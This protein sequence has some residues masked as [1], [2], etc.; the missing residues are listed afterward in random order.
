MTA[1]VLFYHKTCYVPYWTEAVMVRIKWRCA[2]GGGAAEAV[3]RWWEL[4]L[5]VRLGCGTA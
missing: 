3:E 5:R 1:A 2:G 4:E